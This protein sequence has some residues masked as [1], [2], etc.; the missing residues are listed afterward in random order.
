[1]IRSV[2]I[3]RLG[4]LAAALV[5]AACES[6]EA[7]LAGHKARAESFLKDKKA[8][9]AVIEY[10][11]A[12]QIAPN[13]AAA[14]FGLAKAYLMTRDGVGKAPWE[15]E[16]TIR[17][18]PDNFDARLLLA[19]FLLLRGEL[20]KNPDKDKDLAAALDQ[21]DAAVTQQPDKWEAWAVKGRALEELRRVDD[22]QT[23]YQ[24]ALELAPQNVELLRT[25]AGFY[26]RRGDRAGA[27][28]LFKQGVELEPSA[29]SY[30]LLGA[31]LAQDPARAKEAEAAYRKAIELAKDEE[32]PYAYQVLASFYYA[33]E[34]YDES[35][36]LLKEGI[37]K[38]GKNLDLIYWLARFYNSRGAKDR[39]NA[40]IEEAT[41]AKPN[42]VQPLLI[43]SAY[44]GLNNDLPGALDAAERALK[45]DP[46]S[47]PAK[48]R[49][50]ELLVDMGVKDSSKDRLA[51]G[52][53]IVDAVLASEPNSPEAHFVEAKLDL[54]EAKN[55][56]AVAAL[57]KV[58]EG[59][60]DSLPAHFQAQ[61]H[62]LLA[63]AL[64]LQG[65]RQ[66]ARAEVLKAVELDAEFV[67][68]R[69][70]LAH[71]E[72]ALGE[73]DLAIEEARKILR[74]HPD[75]RDMRIVLAQ[76]LVQGGKVDEA[77]SELEAV[78]LD[79]RDAE[80]DFALGRVDML[81]NKP[82]FARQK[83]LAALEL[84]PNHPEILEALLTV[85]ASLGKTQDTLDRLT[86]AEAASPDN[87]AIVRLHGIA[88]IAAGQGSLGEAKLRH[89]IDLNPND[90]ASYSA[91]ARY[92]ILSHRFAESIETYKQAV[93]SRPD[94]APLHFTLGTLYESS[95][96]R[97]DAMAEY[98]EA[99]KLDP[100]LAV[101]KNNLAYLMAEEGKSL[102]RA[103]DLAQAAKASLAESPNAADTLGWV[104]L[105]KGIPVAAIGYLKEAEGGFPSDHLDLGIVRYHLA[106]AY[107][108]N[109]EPDKAKETLERALQGLETAKQAARAGGQ[110]PADPP[111]VA[112][113]RS[114]LQR[115]SQA[116]PPASAPPTS[117]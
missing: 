117:G 96:Q 52:R 32:K 64:M 34:R 4:L 100:N 41:V 44:R 14:H 99:V 76:S 77:R 93:K 36:A 39:A 8:S 89:A 80:V 20:P 61:T 6:R 55:E 86:K 30:L 111:W 51:Q 11:N 107:E 70:L 81:Q 63:S 94:S 74:Q 58:L 48:L 62:F 7:K 82:E 49:K 69:R 115:L 50:A 53:A 40:M 56:E 17:L 37:E 26:V 78:P 42:D 38:T 5:L 2:S 13:D 21:A 91:L 92:F 114:M 79:Q 25:L 112:D 18:A 68:A 57:R 65:E 85:E 67:E 35:E 110:T 54:A 90:L 31:F 12:L 105:K 24:K 59:S 3:V 102:D 1:M 72:A 103:L 46:E 88:L 108:A 87:A 98:E 60:A 10:K 27:E 97:A 33:R 104:L 116:A 75:D 15:L 83:L 19:Q 47:K 113:A 22:G 23:A 9:E 16:E 95:G 45:V 28:P 29:R 71:I 106:M 101:A 66:D 109:H 84:K 43:L 73:R